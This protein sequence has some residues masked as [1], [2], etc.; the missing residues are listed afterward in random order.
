MEA[1]SL[2][3]IAEALGYEAKVTPSRCSIKTYP[4]DYCPKLERW[5]LFDPKTNPAQLLEIIEKLIHLHNLKIQGGF[6]GTDTI[7]T[8]RDGSQIAYGKTLPEA[9]LNAAEEFI[10]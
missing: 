2:R 8:D 10:K 3:K 5:K 7:I 6:S 4:Y 1:E 9:V